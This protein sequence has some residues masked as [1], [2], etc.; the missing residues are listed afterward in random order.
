MTTES[1]QILEAAKIS[2]ADD[3][4]IRN[5][6]RN[7]IW[8][9]LISGMVFLGVCSAYIYYF[10]DDAYAIGKF[11]NG[12]MTL[13][14]YGTIV[15]GVHYF[16]N[17]RLGTKFALFFLV[18]FPLYILNTLSIS[19][20][21]IKELVNFDEKYAGMVLI[22]CIAALVIEINLWIKCK[23]LYLLNRALKQKKSAE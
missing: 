15:A 9:F 7:S 17:M 12:S 3:Q 21:E 22:L 18:V 8:I 23:R 13:L 4:D 11:I 16:G 1:Q 6:C 10:L 19:V 14:V 2:N 5:D 20:L